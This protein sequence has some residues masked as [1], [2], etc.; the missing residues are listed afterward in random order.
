[1]DGR[2]AGAEGADSRDG[3]RN[4]PPLLCAALEIALNR[5]LGLEAGALQACAQMSGRSIELRTF[6]PDGSFFIDFHAGGVRVAPDSPRAADVRVA[7]SAATLLRLAWTAAQGDGGIPQGLQVEGD[8]ELLHR[9]NRVLAG[10]GF[11]PEEL[12]ARL[13]GDAAGHRLAGGLRHVLAWARRSIDTLGLDT[14]EYL[15]EET[16]DLARAA[17]VEEWLAGVERLR[18][19]VARFEMRLR[20]AEARLP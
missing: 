14:A 1:M 2:Q 5:Y 9:F 13:F 15:R 4:T 8:V 17:D 3:V 16:R 18:D 6:S 7:G 10:V 20:R 12:A 11:D 19:D